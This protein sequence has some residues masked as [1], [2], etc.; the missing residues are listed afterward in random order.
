MN[1]NMKM[2]GRAAL[3]GWLL[4]APA[5]L[6]AQP[7][8]FSCTDATGKRL[9][10]DRPLME[11]AGREQRVLNG[12]GSLNRLVPPAMTA[13]ERTAHEERER[14]IAVERTAKLEAVRRDRNLLSRFP[15]E[16]MHDAARAAALDDIRNAS[17]TS[18]ARLVS[19]ATERK[20]LMVEAEFYAGKALPAKLRGQL[21]AIDAAVE[22]QKS[23]NV[24]QQAEMVRVNALFDADLARLRR[25]WAGAE[26][27]TFGSKPSAGT[28]VAM[29]AAPAS[30]PRSSR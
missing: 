24:N 12:D 23:I 6:M 2:A 29:A 5:I 4:G 15:S 16:A 18:Q 8:I 30:S 7:V 9:N 20:P 17:R 13:D 28:G 21:D 25:L 19:L 22:A 3:I 14:R 26:P 11:C 27:G 10:S 1:A